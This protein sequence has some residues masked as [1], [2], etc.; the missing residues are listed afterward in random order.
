MNVEFL[1]IKRVRHLLDIH[2]KMSKWLLSFS[3]VIIAKNIISKAYVH[4]FFGEHDF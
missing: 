1:A 4:L 2:T 3:R